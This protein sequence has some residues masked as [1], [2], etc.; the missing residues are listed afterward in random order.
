MKLGQVDYAAHGAG[1]FA[2][3]TAAVQ[4]DV[5]LAAY[6]ALDPE[7]SIMNLVSFA[8]GGFGA[9]FGPLMIL[10]LFWKRT[11]GKGAIAGIL[12]GFVTVVLWNTFFR[13]GIIT[14]E[15]IMDT[16]VTG[17]YELLPGFVIALVVGVVVSLATP[18]PSAE[19]QREFDEAQ[20]YT[21][22][23]HREQA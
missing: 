20:T 21:E 23:N 17:V 7:S 5:I 2:V 18:E 8:W 6:I 3:I 12:T 4:D 14:K 22:N 15:F 1:C 19:I 9:A 13:S 11:N 16:P 10:S